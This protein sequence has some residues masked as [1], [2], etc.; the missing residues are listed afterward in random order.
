[1]VVAR[2]LWAGRS[3]P[4][5]F[6]RLP[7]IPPSLMVRWLAAI[8]ARAYGSRLLP[9]E[10]LP[11]PTVAVGNLTVGG[12]GKTP[13]ASWIAQYY[14]SRGLR[15]GI[16]LRGYGGDEADVHRRSL[17][18]AVVIEN[19]DRLCGGR[20]AASGGAEVVILDDAYQRLDV[21]R[22]LNIAVVSAE[23]SSAV[24][25]TLPAGP[26]REGWRA[27]KR[28]DLV[29]VTRKRARVEVAQAV[30]R[31]AKRAVG[32]RPVALARLGITGFSGMLSGRGFDPGELRDAKVVV[33]A[34]I[35][36]PYAFAAQCRGLGAEVS[37]IAWRDHQRITERYAM[38]LARTGRSADY[39]V[40]T[41]KDAVKLRKHWPRH[42]PEPLVALLEL[43]WERGGDVVRAALDAT[44][45][46][47]EELVS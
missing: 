11:L 3:L 32:H 4:A 37:L 18:G 30:A 22:D 38:K 14:S 20:E 16:V 13:L 31:R 24:P 39:V 21:D 1:M 9:H 19:P 45:E 35:A 8:R 36:D 25:W 17:P 29:V 41:E 23:S 15:P 46:G 42:R 28:A 12:S 47:V 5:R 26:W 6:A 40:V 10:S 27:L 2:W 33:A 7:L 34:G 43:S 44:V